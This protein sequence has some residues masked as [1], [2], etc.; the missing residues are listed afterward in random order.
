MTERMSFFKV[1]YNHLYGLIKL[2]AYRED[3]SVHA[4]ALLAY[5]RPY[6]DNTMLDFKNNY[7]DEEYQRKMHKVKTIMLTL[8]RNE[9]IPYSS[10]SKDKRIYS[11]YDLD[12]EPELGISRHGSDSDFV[13]ENLMMFFYY[14]LSRLTFK[15]DDIKSMNYML[16]LGYSL[17][18]PYLIT[19]DRD[20]WIFAN[21]LK[22]K[23]AFKYESI[24]VKM[25]CI[26]FI[27][28][29]EGFQFKQRFV[30]EMKV[31]EAKYL[32]TNEELYN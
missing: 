9:I 23:K 15:H 28:N 29:R 8:Y 11:E 20:K 2:C 25:E 31:E 16:D 1:I 19:T 6:M 5:L 22:N 7:P 21:E 26:S 18:T 4:D 17:L 3:I 12:Y 24:K 32:G 14:Y 27:L 30:D 13:F 10:S